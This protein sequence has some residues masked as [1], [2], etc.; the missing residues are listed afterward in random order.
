[1][2]QLKFI[3]S[4]CIPPS[5]AKIFQ[6]ES[7]ENIKYTSN[8]IRTE[9]HTNTQTQEHFEIINI[10]KEEVYIISIIHTKFHTNIQLSMVKFP[11]ADKNSK[12]SV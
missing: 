7:I 6:Q 8:N 1:M 5:L 11:I 4:I 2:V 12:T 9:K 3:L 10:D